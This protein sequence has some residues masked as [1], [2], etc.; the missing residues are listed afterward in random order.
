MKPSCAEGV[1]WGQV[2][3]THRTCWVSSKQLWDITREGPTLYSISIAVVLPGEGRKSVRPPPPDKVFYY[4]Y[5]CTAVV[6][7][8]S[9]FRENESSNVRKVVQYGS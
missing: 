5:C 7:D 9:K 1:R 8:E 4:S 6:Q 2:Q 3:L